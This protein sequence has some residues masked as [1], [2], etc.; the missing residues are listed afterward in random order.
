VPPPQLHACSNG[1][2][3]TAE[4]KKNKNKDTLLREMVARWG[5]LLL[6]ILLRL[7]PLL[8]YYFRLL[9][10]LLSLQANRSSGQMRM[11]ARLC[12]GGCTDGAAA[13]LDRWPG[14]G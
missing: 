9:A 10:P 8:I 3:G 11:R 5:L 4:E 7:L 2:H 6:H 13:V 1:N 12:G 14:Y